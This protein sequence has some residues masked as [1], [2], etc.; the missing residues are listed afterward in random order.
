MISMIFVLFLISERILSL[1]LLIIINIII[2][3]INIINYQYVAT[4]TCSAAATSTTTTTTIATAA[5]ST[6][7][8]N[9]TAATDDDDEEEDNIHNNDNN[10]DIPAL[11]SIIIKSTTANLWT[12]HR[13]ITWDQMWISQ[14]VVN[15]PRDRNCSMVG[16]KTKRSHTQ[17]SHPL[18]QSQYTDTEPTSPS[19]DPTTPGVVTWVPIFKARHGSAK[20]IFCLSSLTSVFHT[21][22]CTITFASQNRLF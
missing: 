2:I 10:N 18:T 1:I 7:T 5:A 22:R 19:T 16:L 4:A 21:N 12:K 17:N 8:T 20:M 13:L 3:I 9:S 6:S 15:F 11:A 14:S